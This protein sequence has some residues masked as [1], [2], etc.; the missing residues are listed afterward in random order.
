MRLVAV[1]CGYVSPH[2]GRWWLHELAQGVVERLYVARHHVGRQAE[3][4]AFGA[5][6]YGGLPDGEGLDAVAGEKLS[7]QLY[8]LMGVAYDE[9]LDV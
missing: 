2:M 7:R 3:T 5:C 8:C 4:E 1:R 6:R 9:R